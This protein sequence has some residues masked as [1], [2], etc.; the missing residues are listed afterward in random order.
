LPHPERDKPEI[1]DQIDTLSRN[2]GD[3]EFSKACRDG[4]AFDP[5]WIQEW[6]NRKAGAQ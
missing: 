5:E 6:L 3:D 2:H 1:S 4:R